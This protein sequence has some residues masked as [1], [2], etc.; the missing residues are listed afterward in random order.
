[1]GYRKSGS[2][3]LWGGAVALAVLL[4]AG[5]LL[6]T[7]FRSA[8]KP[9]TAPV[10]AAFDRECEAQVLGAIRQAK[11]EIL[12]SI[13]TLTR[14]S[15]TG[16]L[17]S[18]AGRGVTVRVKYN[19]SAGDEKEGMEDAIKFLRKRNVECIAV[20]MGREGLMHHKFVVVDRKCVVTGSY[21]YTTQAS[22]RN[23]EN[24][25]VIDSPEIA[26]QFAAEFELIASP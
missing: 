19:V 16:A 17:A 7:G 3:G 5:G 8:P 23:F 21:N 2:R 26:V 15:I 20:R 10:R 24:V 25:V 1:M 9:V 22:A 14:R 4:A 11:S 12:V 6:G 18:A 13:Y